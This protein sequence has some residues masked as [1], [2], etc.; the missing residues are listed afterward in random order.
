[1]FTKLGER[2]DEHSENFNKEIRNIRKYQ[3]EVTEP[4]I[5]SLN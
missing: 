3:I 1:M 4:K 2:M 5:Q